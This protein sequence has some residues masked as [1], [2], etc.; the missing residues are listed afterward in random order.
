MP[1]G[2]TDLAATSSDGESERGRLVLVGSQDMAS[3]GSSSIVQVAVQLQSIRSRS[4]ENGAGGFRVQSSAFFVC[5][6]VGVSVGAGGVGGQ[7][8]YVHAPV[9]EAAQT[10]WLQRKQWNASR[11]GVQSRG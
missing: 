1:S 3:D 5:P 2:Q 11:R 4:G 8:E 6:A 10:L 9:R 7:P